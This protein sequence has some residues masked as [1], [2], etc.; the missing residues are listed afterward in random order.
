M[1][2]WDQTHPLLDQND[3][4]RRT[5]FV[6]TACFMM[7]LVHLGKKPIIHIDEMSHICIFRQPQDEMLMRDILNIAGDVN[8]RP[9]FVGEELESQLLL[10][11]VLPQLHVL[12]ALAGTRVVAAIIDHHVRPRQARV[13][14]KCPRRRQ[15]GAVQSVGLW[16]ELLRDKEQ[17]GP[18]NA[19]LVQHEQMLWADRG[20]H[21]TWIWIQEWVPSCTCLALRCIWWDYRFAA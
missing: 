16:H 10:T 14:K 12:V 1:P 2:P 17:A 4:V 3:I 9:C 18:V 11:R 20:Q 19:V 13:T 5:S 7:S 15:I 8:F 21:E 6:A